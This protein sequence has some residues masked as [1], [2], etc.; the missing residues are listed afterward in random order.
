MYSIL[1]PDNTHLIIGIKE[2]K[3]IIPNYSDKSQHYH[4]KPHQD[5]IRNISCTRD[6]EYFI[7]SSAD[8]TTK[9]F[10]LKTKTE[11]VKL[12]GSGYIYGQ[13]L[14]TGATDKTVRAWRI[15]Q[16]S[17]VAQF[18]VHRKQSGV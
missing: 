16:P 11:A 10:N 1:T 13:F 17:R 14:V 5:E 15:G 9:I 2:H 6:G 7:T 8:K 3:V 12:E 4:F 18:R